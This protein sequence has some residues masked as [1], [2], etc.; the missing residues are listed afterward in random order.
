MSFTTA[1]SEFK[2]SCIYFTLLN[3]VVKST[4]CTKNAAL[5]FMFFAKPP[6]PFYKIFDEAPRNKVSNCVVEKF[7]VSLR[8]MY[9]KL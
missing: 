6:N 7:W 5:V 9:L 4:G 3:A 2:E 8:K 1:I